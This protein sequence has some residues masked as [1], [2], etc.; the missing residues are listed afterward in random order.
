MRVDLDF[1]VAAVIPRLTDGGELG[2]LRVGRVLSKE[3]IESVRVEGRDPVG[4]VV[5][6]CGLVVVF[7]IVVALSYQNLGVWQILGHQS[8]HLLRNV[9]Q[10]CVAR[11][12]IRW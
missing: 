11:R 10:L 12:A 2:K 6:A 4:A 5:A 1:V 7:G 9:Q 3:P 8:S